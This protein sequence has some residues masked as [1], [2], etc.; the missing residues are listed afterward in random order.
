MLLMRDLSN[1]LLETKLP[2]H[3]AFYG[4]EGEFSG[5]KLFYSS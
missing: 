4:N 3:N 2:G 1:E 5:L